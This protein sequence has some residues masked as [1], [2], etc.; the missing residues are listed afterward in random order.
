MSQTLCVLEPNLTG[1]NAAGWAVLAAAQQLVQPITVLVVGEACEALA[2]QVATVTGVNLV[3]VFEDPALAHPLAE[4]LTPLLAEY[5]A[6][7]SHVVMAATT[8]GKNLL[9]RLAAL[10]DASPI[11]DVLAIE[12]ADQFVRPMYAGNVQVT[13]TSSQPQQLLSVRVSAFAKAAG[14]LQ[15]APE[16]A[17]AEINV[18]DIELPSVKSRFVAY[19]SP[20]LARPALSEATVVLTGGRG[21]GSAENFEQLEQLAT[22]IG[23]AVG[24]TRAAVDAGYVPNDY[25]VGQT[26]QVVAPDLYIAFGVSGAIQHVAG[27]SDSRVVVAI[28]QDPDAPIFSVANYGLVMD[29]FEA[30]AQFDQALGTVTDG[31]D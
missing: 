8:F 18:L 19:Q 11:S 25:Q 29:L 6:Q 7:M 20:T 22:R 16:Q 28:N 2:A 4:Q 14:Q 10:L 24:A 31:S 13:V 12:A 27:M 9:P 21:F 26:G 30:L 23:A 3:Q 15:Q 17:A 5:S 1:L